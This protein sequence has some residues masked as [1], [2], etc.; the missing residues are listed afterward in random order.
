MKEMR[1][2]REFYF[3]AAH[4]LPDYDGKCANLHGH[5]YK[6]EVVVSG[7]VKKKSGMVVDFCDIK[8]AVNEAVIERLDHANLNDIFSNPTAENMAVWIF[9]EIRKKLPELFSV[10]LWEGQHSWVE[11]HGEGR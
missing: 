8:K 11:Y 10:K 9:D 3:D 5:T 2:C 1:L 7:N 6:L 4:R